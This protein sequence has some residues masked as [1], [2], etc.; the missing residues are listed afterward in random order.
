MSH[1]VVGEPQFFGRN[2]RL[3][4]PAG[5]WFTVT[6]A[7]RMHAEYER[8]MYFV[9]NCRFTAAVLR[10]TFSSGV[11]FSANDD[12]CLVGRRGLRFFMSVAFSLRERR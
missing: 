8:R 9:I 10:V 2:Q 7:D 3:N 4:A 12:V 1:L 11:A 6:L 5:F